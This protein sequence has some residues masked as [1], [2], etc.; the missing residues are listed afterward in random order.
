M[1][2]ISVIMAVPVNVLGIAMIV[3]VVSA[4][5]RVLGGLMMVVAVK[6]AATHDGIA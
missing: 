2:A 6:Q 1:V 5:R 4:R 3:M